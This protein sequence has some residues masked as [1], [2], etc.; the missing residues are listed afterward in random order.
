[1][2][3]FL[4]IINISLTVAAIVLTRNLINPTLPANSNST[5]TLLDTSVFEQTG[6]EDETGMGLPKLTRQE[7]DILWEKNLFHP[8]RTFE[9]SLIEDLDIKEPEQVNEHFEL[10]SIAQVANKSCASIRVIKKARSQRRRANNRRNNR[11][12]KSPKKDTNQKI[13]ML[14]DSVG[15]TGFKLTEIGIDYIVIKKGDQELTLRLDKGD[16]SSEKRRQV[17]KK[18]IDAKTKKESAA[19]NRVEASKKKQEKEPEK[20]VAKDTPKKTIPPPPPPPAFNRGVQQP[21]TNQNSTNTSSAGQG[22]S[23]YPRPIRKR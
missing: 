21:A 1:M 4:I 20:E 10:M 18:K 13:Y 5:S 7:S 6:M 12:A 11:R 23:Q 2:G 22:N 8:E 17:A 19:R 15:E 14:N 9:E 16:E 3:K